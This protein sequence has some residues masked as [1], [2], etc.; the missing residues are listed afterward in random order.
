MFLSRPIQWYRSHADLIWLEGTSQQCGVLEANS[1]DNCRF[2][3]IVPCKNVSQIIFHENLPPFVL[4]W[5]TTHK[6]AQTS[7]CLFCWTIN[8]EK[9][10][11]IRSCLSDSPEA[12]TQ[13]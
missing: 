7:R 2:L 13:I 11:K 6:K 5:N 12:T 1:N 8:M 10:L 3:S 9:I 4:R